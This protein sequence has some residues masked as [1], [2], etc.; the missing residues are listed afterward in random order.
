M[1][2]FDELELNTETLRDLSA[3]ELGAVAGGVGD[4]AATCYCPTIY[5]PQDCVE[6]YIRDTLITCHCPG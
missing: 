2:E 6:I 5:P 1:R 4:L 3:D